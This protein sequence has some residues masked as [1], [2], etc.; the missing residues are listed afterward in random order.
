MDKAVEPLGKSK[1]R[2]KKNKKPIP[3]G[4]PN[5]GRKPMPTTI[6]SYT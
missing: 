5:V 4:V 6:R 3:G 2:G 1:K